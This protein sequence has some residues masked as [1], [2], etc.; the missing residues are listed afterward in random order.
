MKQEETNNEINKHNNYNMNKVR[1]ILDVTLLASL[2]ALFFYGCQTSLDENFT[3]EGDNL[4]S[5]SRSYTD[6]F[7]NIDLAKLKNGDD[8]LLER[9][10]QARQ[11][12]DS[13]VRFQDGQYYFTI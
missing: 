9:Y 5:L 13:V 2:T 12:L 11:R 10:K 3:N 1:F 7:I 8:N 6:N 4:M